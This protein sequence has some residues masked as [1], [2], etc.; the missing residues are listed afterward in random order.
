MRY[1]DYH[2]SKYEVSDRGETITFHLVYGYPGQESDQSCIRFSNVAFYDF[3]HT[4]NAIIV[5]IY[6]ISV[7]EFI[8]EFG[9]DLTELNRMYRVRLMSGSLDEYA[10]TLSNENYRAWRIE[11][12]IGF[13]GVIVA[14]TID[15]D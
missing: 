12:A 7:S 13:S 3:S 14:K 6:E 1:H 11:A 15:S 5:E 8:E 4:D 2:L 10:L 9:T